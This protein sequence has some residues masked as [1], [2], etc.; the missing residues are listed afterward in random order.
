MDI[1]TSNI[2]NGILNGIVFVDFRKVF[3]MEDLEILIQKL[4]INIYRCDHLMLSW[5]KTYLQ[6]KQQCVY[7]EENLS[8]KKPVC[9]GVPHG[10]ILGPLLFIIF[11]NDLPL[12]VTSNID[13]YPDDSTIHTSAK[14]VDDS[15]HLSNINNMVIRSREN[16]N[17]V[18]N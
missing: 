7:I 8:S 2:D 18:N 3:D 17:N 5:F 13:M 6:G 12:W 9:F 1:W 10:S 14:I 11:I 16:E 15:T 4:S